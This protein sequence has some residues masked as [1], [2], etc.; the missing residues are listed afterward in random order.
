MNL[1]RTALF[2]AHQAANALLVDFAGWEM[3]VHYG[4]QLEEHHVVRSDAGMFDVSHMTVLDVEG[5]DATAFL[6]YLLANDVEKLTH[7]GRALY[8]CMLNEDGGIVDDLII[9]KLGEH[10]YRAIVNAATRVKD[11]AWFKMQ[12]I[13]FDVT[14]LE[15]SDLS[16]LAVQGPKACAKADSIFSDKQCQA[17]RDLT[18]FSAAFLDDVLI[19]K[20][21]YTG[22]MGYE[23]IIPNDQAQFY[24]DSL[25]SAGVRPCGLGARDTLRL[26]A[27][28][29]LYGSDM[30]EDF[31]P[32]ESNLMWTVVMND[33]DFIGKK[34]LKDM[35]ADHAILVGL[36]LHDRG[37]LRSHQTVVTEQQSLGETTSGTFS[38]TLKR[39]IALARVP[40]DVGDE[41]NV[42]VRGKL[43]RAKIVKLPFVK[44]GKANFELT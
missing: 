19:A 33:R 31:T 36:V 20:T 21:G 5:P 38:P 7:L 32:Q 43:L 2:A 42:D 25:L 18:Y 4:S 12:A 29:N 28:L 26:E 14:I 17:V 27:G 34:A 22:E 13:A 1:K 30:D 11:I 16:I 6:R 24:W 37:V 39:G 23:I 9:Y 10:F 3:P 35:P 15:R 41:C 40:C 44:K 8:T